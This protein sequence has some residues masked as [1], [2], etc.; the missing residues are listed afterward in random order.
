MDKKRHKPFAFL[1]RQY[2][3]QLNWTTYGKEA[4]TNVKVLD[5]MYYVLWGPNP[6]RV[7]TYHRNFFFRA[8]RNKAQF[9]KIHLGKGLQVGHTSVTVW[10]HIR[11]HQRSQHCLCWVAHP[12]KQRAQIQHSTIYCGGGF[13][14]KH[15]TCSRNSKWSEPRWH[16]GSPDERITARYRDLK[17]RG[18]VGRKWLHL[19]SRER[20]RT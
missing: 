20:G 3:K 13:I 18:I 4:F 2:T 12:L 1:G 6:V 14:Q 9:S 8:D 16:K 11:T 19:D 10:L 7:H 15:C 5:C 17:H